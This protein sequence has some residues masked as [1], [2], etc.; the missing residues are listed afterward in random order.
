MNNESKKSFSSVISFNVNV[1]QSTTPEV[2][3]PIVTQQAFIEAV[4]VTLTFIPVIPQKSVS[5]STH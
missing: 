1:K 3:W 2:Y 4:I 5:Y